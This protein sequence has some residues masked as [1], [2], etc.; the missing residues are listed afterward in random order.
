[1][2]EPWCDERL[3][4][5]YSSD[6]YSSFTTRTQGGAAV[7]VGSDSDARRFSRSSVLPVLMGGRAAASAVVAVGAAGGGSMT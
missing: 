6:S 1:M 4:A 5:V 2:Y 7:A 3:F